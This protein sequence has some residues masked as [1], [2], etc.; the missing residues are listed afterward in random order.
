MSEPTRTHPAPERLRAFGLGRLDPPETDGVAAH[1]A[2][3]P[4]CTRALEALPDDTLVA[5]LRG[6]DPVEEGL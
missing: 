2:G 4:G 1:L 3:C 6:A 5:L